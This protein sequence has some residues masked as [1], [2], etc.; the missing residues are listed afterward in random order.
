MRINPPI[1]ATHTYTQQLDGMPAEVFP[2]LCPVRE[3]EWVA[4][5]LPGV[6]YSDS[7][8]AERDCIFTT[9][10]GERE[11]VWAI[12]EHD[13]A[14]GVVEMLKL[15]PGYLVTRLRITLAPSPRGGTAATVTYTYTALGPEG[16]RYVAERTEA[17]YEEFMRTWEAALNR[18]LRARRAA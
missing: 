11:A 9:P 4:G 3:V 16:E 14:G 7:G 17:A 18:Y 6:V 10:D 5:W 12:I 2:L 15:T 1:R 8:V 13:P